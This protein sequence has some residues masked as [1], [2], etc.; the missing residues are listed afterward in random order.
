MDT[1]G[2]AAASA[3]QGPIQT[4]YRD[5]FQSTV[6]PSFDKACQGLFM[7]VNES[8]QRGTKDCKLKIYGT[9]GW[10]Q[11]RLVGL[12]HASVRNRSQF[13]RSIIGPSERPM[14]D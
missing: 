4:A 3:I 7:Q 2:A 11:N 5:I 1:L 8:F 10:P 13:S 14:T 12:M 9:H 6:L